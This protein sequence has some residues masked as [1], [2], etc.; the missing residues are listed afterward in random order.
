MRIAA[1]FFVA[2]LAL[3]IA[4]VAELG[5]QPLV[6]NAGP[7]QVGTKFVGDTVQMNGGASV[8]ATTYAWTFTR[9]PSGSAATLTNP[10]SVTPTFVPDRGGSYTLRLVVG[11]GTTTASDTVIVTTINRPPVANAGVDRTSQIGKSVLL[12][13]TASSDPDLNKLT[14]Q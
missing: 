3:T 11:N 12:D 4:S 1:R 10:A 14:Y 2:L 9:R 13:G 8:G 7:D 5:A 6:P